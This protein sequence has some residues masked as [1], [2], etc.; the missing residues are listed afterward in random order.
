MSNFIS[1][2]GDKLI[3]SSNYI[4]WKINADLFLEIN[5]YMSYIDG[6]EASPNKSLY[7]KIETSINK[8][9]KETR[10][11]GSALSSEL[12][13]RYADRLSEF[14]YNNKRALD[15]LK[16]IISIDNNN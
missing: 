2:K 16:S 12:G 1:F 15:A 8:E 9:G 3:G 5:G 11:Y 7:Y 10:S 13:A 6:T 14:N 4:E